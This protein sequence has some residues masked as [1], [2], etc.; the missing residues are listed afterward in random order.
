MASEAGDRSGTMAGDH[1]LPWLS[2]LQTLN[3]PF[4]PGRSR[5]LAMRCSHLIIMMPRAGISAHGSTGRRSRFAIR[6]EWSDATYA[7]RAQDIEKLIDALSK[8]PR[9]RLG[10]LRLEPSW[11]GGSFARRIY[12]SRRGG[13]W[14]HWNDPRVKAI[15]ALSPYAAPFINKQ[16]LGGLRRR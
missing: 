10:A 7:D 9:F 1:F 12:G 14:A 11:A 16:T 8:D 6:L 4:L 2:R 13:G 3:R 5:I 15:L